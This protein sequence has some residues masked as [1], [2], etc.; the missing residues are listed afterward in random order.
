MASG[1]RL[2]LRLSSLDYAGLRGERWIPVP[3][4]PRPETRLT[5]QRPE[6]DRPPNFDARYDYNVLFRGKVVGRMWRYEYRN[7]PWQDQPPW[8]WDWRGVP[9][10]PDTEGHAPTLES[11]MA[12]FR[13]AWDSALESGAA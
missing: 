6:Y 13:K 2:V 5:L 4:R 9:G 12:D 1:G 8:H 3:L 11:A 10:R 7:H